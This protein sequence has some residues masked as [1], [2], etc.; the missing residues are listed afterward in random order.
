MTAGDPEL[1]THALQSSKATTVKE[2]RC[3]CPTAPSPPADVQECLSIVSR[4]GRT[5]PRPDGTVHNDD[6]SEAS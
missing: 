5:P 3:V 2:G 6:T 1:G 4:Q